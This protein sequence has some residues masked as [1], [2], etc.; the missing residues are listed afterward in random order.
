MHRLA[1]LMAVDQRADP[2]LSLSDTAAQVLGGRRFV[3]F[4]ACRRY[5]KHNLKTVRLGAKHGG[6]FRGG[7]H[8]RYEGGRVR[9]LLSL[10]SYLS[11]GEYRDRFVGVKIPRT[12]LQERHLAEPDLRRR[13]ADGLAHAAATTKA[14]R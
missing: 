11:S 8:F 10:I 2:F 3:A 1:G 4:V 13:A 14:T 12:N 7:I 9:S 5:W 6:V